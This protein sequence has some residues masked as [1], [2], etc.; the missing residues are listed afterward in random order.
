MET[1]RFALSWLVLACCFPP[2][3]QAQVADV[4]PPAVPTPAEKPSSNSGKD[5]ANTNDKNQSDG[6]MRIMAY[7]TAVPTADQAKKIPPESYTRLV[8][9]NM[10]S[11]EASDA[12]NDKRGRVRRLI[13][14]KDVIFEVSL[15][16][17]AGRYKEITPLMYRRYESGRKNGENFSRE[18][19]IDDRF[20]PLFLVSGDPSHQIARF[21]LDTRFD[22]KPSTDTAEFSLGFL[23]TA[24]K[25]IS[26]GSSVV[27]TLTSEAS[28][29]V[30][31]KVDESIGKF[32]AKSVKEK[33]R[34]DVDLYE[35][36]P[37]MITI[38]GATQESDGLEPNRV[39]GKWLISFAPARP[40]I[41][42][43]IAC[44][45]ETSS[46]ACNTESKKAA[47]DDAKNRPQAVLSFALIDKIG[48]SGTILSY[49][50]QQAWWDQLAD[51]K[52]EG[53]YGTFCRR[54]RGAMAEIGL[55]DTDGKIIA[56]AVSQSGSVSQDAKTGM[57]SAGD[58]KFDPA[59]A[60]APDREKPVTP[61][62]SG[63]RRT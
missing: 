25:A 36:K 41:F 33:L 12:K 45:P 52:A 24:L 11:A 34:F 57:E 63:A 20:F 56:Y 26:P 27:T 59:G 4:N 23:S 42:S 3:A 14:S 43:S 35:Y 10:L 6:Q 32:F 38:K 1:H 16:A 47:F 15:T 37:I 21:T 5:A 31:S 62:P 13:S 9:T 28:D 61:T 18:L 46:E 55:S 49:L 22:F 50:K 19:T 40:S 53:D 58:C 30:A 48:N 39:I 51:L 2:A 8:I 17:E 60:R 7:A 29:K 54:I 44:E